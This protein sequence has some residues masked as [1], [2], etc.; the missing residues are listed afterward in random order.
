MLTPPP[1]SCVGM[2]ENHYEYVR[3]LIDSTYTMRGIVR[4]LDSFIFRVL[5]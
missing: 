1:R 5:I 4:L 3:F 2:R